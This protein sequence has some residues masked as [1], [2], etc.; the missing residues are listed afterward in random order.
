MSCSGFHA[1][2][3]Q[4]LFEG[5]HTINGFTLAFAAKW[6]ISTA[7]PGLVNVYKKLLK[8]AIEIVIFPMKNG[9]FPVRYVNVYQRVTHHQCHHCHPKSHHKKKIQQ[10]PRSQPQ[11]PSAVV[12]AADKSDVRRWC[13]CPCLEGLAPHSLDWCKG[14]SCRNLYM[15]VSENSVPLNPMVLLIIIPIKWLFH[16]EYTLFSDK[17]LYLMVKNKNKHGAQWRCSLKNQSNDACVALLYS[18]ILWLRI[19]KD[20]TTQTQSATEGDSVTANG[21]RLLLHFTV[22]FQVS[23]YLKKWVSTTIQEC[24]LFFFI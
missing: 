18:S 22:C 5:Q 24:V 6:T 14:K 11:P 8:M 1:V 4:A 19:V 10:P 16:W 9:D 17:P 3:W 23:T 21:C 13:F 20:D 7:I 2:Q 15:G 12:A